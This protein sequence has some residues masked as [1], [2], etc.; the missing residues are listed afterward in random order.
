MIMTRVNNISFYDYSTGSNFSCQI[1]LRG[2][3]KGSLIN[4]T[5]IN[6]PESLLSY[7]EI[8]LEHGLISSSS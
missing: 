3:G 4:L 2:A 8:K 7:V 6:F 5:Y 1:N